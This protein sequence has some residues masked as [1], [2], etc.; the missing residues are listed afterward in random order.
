MTEAK[1]KSVQCFVL[2]N[3]VQVGKVSVS[4]KTIYSKNYVANIDE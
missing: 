3:S 4:M 1:S 2:C